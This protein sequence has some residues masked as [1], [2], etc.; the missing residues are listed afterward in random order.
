MVMPGEY[1]S[2]ATIP[3][4][5]LGP[6]RYT[7]RIRAGIYGVRLLLPK[8]GLAIPF[9]VEL[10]KPYSAAYPGDPFWGKICA[11]VNWNTTRTDRG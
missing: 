4:D 5:I 6:L 10:S 1:V 8:D 3:P 2:R 11:N 7:L 9:H